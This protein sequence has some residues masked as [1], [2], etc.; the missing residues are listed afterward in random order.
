[1]TFSGIWRR[2]AIEWILRDAIWRESRARVRLERT[3][4]ASWA[5]RALIRTVI[6]DTVELHRDLASGRSYQ[7]VTGH[8]IHFR[9]DLGALTWPG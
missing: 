5:T 7:V 9:V 8:T 3:E 6:V 4:D 1:M 2:E